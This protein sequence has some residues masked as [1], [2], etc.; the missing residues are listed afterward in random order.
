M[1]HVPT[2]ST[3]VWLP[4]KNSN[5]SHHLKPP[6]FTPVLLF[7]LTRWHH[8]TCGRRLH[9]IALHCTAPHSILPPKTEILLLHPVSMLPH[10]PLTPDSCIHISHSC[11]HVTP[12]TGHEACSIY[13]KDNYTRVWIA[14]EATK[15]VVLRRRST[16]SPQP[17]SRMWY[18]FFNIKRFGGFKYFRTS[19]P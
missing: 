2:C 9:C 1:P 12:T 13:R 15:V 19:D 18:Y 4:S 3:V 8:G 10:L 17:T 16:Y 11:N 6:L 7:S 5:K 14:S